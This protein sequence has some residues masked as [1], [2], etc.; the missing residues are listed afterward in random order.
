MVLQNLRLRL[1]QALAPVQETRR[2]KRHALNLT[3]DHGSLS[4][5]ILPTRNSDIALINSRRGANRGTIMRPFLHG[6]SNNGRRMD[7]AT[8]CRT[9]RACRFSC[10]TTIRKFPSTSPNRAEAR[11]ARRNV[12]SVNADPSPA[13]RTR[14]NNRRRLRR[15]HNWQE[16]C[17]E[18]P[19]RISHRLLL[20]PQRVA[21]PPQTESFPFL[22]FA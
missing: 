5:R 21:V 7:S 12:R 2:R 11:S 13:K 6:A 22:S 15:A 3:T 19:P 1:G 20:E 10:G 8:T 14:R 4:P 18:S 9:Q 16:P 17:P